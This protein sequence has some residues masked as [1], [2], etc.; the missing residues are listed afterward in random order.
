MLQQFQEHGSAVSNRKYPYLIKTLRYRNM[1]ESLSFF[2]IV[3]MYVY[4]YT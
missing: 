4:G 3:I 2:Q 1:S